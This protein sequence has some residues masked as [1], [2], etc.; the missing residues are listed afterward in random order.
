MSIIN[1]L[2]ERSLADQVLQRMKSSYIP[3][4]KEI[5]SIGG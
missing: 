4:R 3:R 5:E 2:R 1:L